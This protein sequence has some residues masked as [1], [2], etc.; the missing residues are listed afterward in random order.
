MLAKSTLVGSPSGGRRVGGQHRAGES[1]R[2]RRRVSGPGRRPGEF[3]WA[4]RLCPQAV[5]TPQRI[6]AQPLDA[7][8]LAVACGSRGVSRRHLSRQPFGARRPS[9]VAPI[10]A[11][12]RIA[13]T[14]TRETSR[15]GLS[16]SARPTKSSSPRGV[17]APQQQWPL[18][19]RP[20]FA[21]DRDVALGALAAR[22][23]RCRAIAARHVGH[24]LVPPQR[25]TLGPATPP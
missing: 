3:C 15:H 4:I 19:S 20:R 5:P 16:P 23:P 12:H 18:G 17:R 11:R 9:R 14:S 10:R 25:Q 6:A 13:P 8:S 22:R 7:Y 1:C 21:R 2:A 24:L